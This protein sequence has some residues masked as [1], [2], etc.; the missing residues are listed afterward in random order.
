LYKLV[1]SKSDIWST[2]ANEEFQNLGM[3]EKRFFKSEL[4][5][6]L[7]VNNLVVI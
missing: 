5:Q 2:L 3:G 4:F 6:I 1:D 7:F